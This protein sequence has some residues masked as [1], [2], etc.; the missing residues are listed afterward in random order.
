M[1]FREKGGEKREKKFFLFSLRG[2]SGWHIV[3]VT[4]ETVSGRS[5]REKQGIGDVGLS[6]TSHGEE[7]PFVLG[8][9]EGTDQAGNNHHYVDENDREDL[10]QGKSGGQEEIEE[11]ERSGD[12]PINCDGKNILLDPMRF[13]KI[14]KKLTITC[15]PDGTGRVC[16]SSS[17]KI[18]SEVSSPDVFN[19]DGS[20]SEISSH[21]EAGEKNSRSGSSLSH[22]RRR[23]LLGN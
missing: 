3:K 21:A 4:H 1:E 8:V 23:F 14:M 11:E 5:S 17:N 7:T 10:T 6:G 16:N 9:D 22:C 2:E 20:S 18:S 12:G 19:D 15:V 13:R